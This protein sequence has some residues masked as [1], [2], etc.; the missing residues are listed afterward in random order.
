MATAMSEAPRIICTR[1]VRI[2]RVTHH[3]IE[4]CFDGMFVATVC[5]ERRLGTLSGMTLHDRERQI[6]SNDVHWLKPDELQRYVERK[7]AQAVYEQ[8]HARLGRWAMGEVDTP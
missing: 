8:R 4:Q 7:D 2:M 5:C 6:T 1:C 3:E